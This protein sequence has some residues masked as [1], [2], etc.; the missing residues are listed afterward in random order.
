MLLKNQVT[1]YIIMI[2]VGTVLLE[3]AVFIL[4]VFLVLCLI[5]VTQFVRGAELFFF[6][7]TFETLGVTLQYLECIIGL[8]NAYLYGV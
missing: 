7:N 4:A 2:V 1:L 6:N 8:K 3:L 5:E